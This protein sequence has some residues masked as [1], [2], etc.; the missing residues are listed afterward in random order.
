MHTA[1]HAGFRKDQRR[2]EYASGL[3]EAAGA[4]LGRQK[5]GKASQVFLGPR[6]PL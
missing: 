4:T 2:S 1:A 3:L 5:C 6:S